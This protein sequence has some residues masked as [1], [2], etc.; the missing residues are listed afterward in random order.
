MR[1]LIYVM[2]IFLPLVG[3]QT[4]RKAV[5]GERKAEKLQKKREKEAQKL[6]EAGLERHISSQSP[7]TRARMKENRRKSE[8]WIKQNKKPPFY[9]RWFRKRR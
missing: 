7:E 2:I 6:Y 9:K 1:L 4:N 8:R 5:K 3:C